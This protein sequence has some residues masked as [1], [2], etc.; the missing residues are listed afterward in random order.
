M[1]LYH[2]V[3]RGCFFFS[4]RVYL[5]SLKNLDDREQMKMIFNCE[6]YFTMLKNMRLRVLFGQC[7]Y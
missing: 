4:N 1:V 2:N 7:I 6:K 3:S 5:I